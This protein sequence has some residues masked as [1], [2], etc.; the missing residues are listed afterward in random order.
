M[1]KRGKTC[2]QR[3]ARE[4]MQSAPSAG[5]HAV[6]IKR[7]INARKPVGFASGTG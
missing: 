5:K 3:Q 4:N 2:S 7:W 1:Y 6:G